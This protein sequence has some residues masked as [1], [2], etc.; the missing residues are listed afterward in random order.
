MIETIGRGESVRSVARI[1][2]QIAE[3]YAAAHIHEEGGNNRGDQVEF[4]QRLISGAPGDPWCADFVCSCLVKAYARF[5]RLP[6]D[7]VRLPGYV[8]AAGALMLPLSGSCVE[9]A[10]SARRL[11]LLRS[12]DYSPAAGDLVLFD[13]ADRGEPHHIGFVRSADHAVIH[14]V[15]GNTS[16]G[17]HGSQADGEGVFC[18]VR[19]RQ[20]VHGFVHFA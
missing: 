12:A 5:H 11:K 15:E 1:G 10:R 9:I 6:E 13:F 19:P 18:R 4:F 8:A 7:R 20:H 2:L 16:P 14:T 17:T 3:G